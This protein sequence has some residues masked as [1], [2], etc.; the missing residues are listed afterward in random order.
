MCAHIEDEPRFRGL[1]AGW[2][3]EGSVPSYPLFMGET[4]KKQ[5][6]RKRKYDKEA[7]EAEEMRREMGLKD[8]GMYRTNTY[9]LKNSLNT[10]TSTNCCSSYQVG[11]L[12]LIW[13]VYYICHM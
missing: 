4:E 1:I 9:I 2:I 11:L 12:L 8:D 7:Q 13:N 10:W 3:A 6:K 5:K